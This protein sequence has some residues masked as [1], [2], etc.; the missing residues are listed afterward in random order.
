MTCYLRIQMLMYRYLQNEV[1]KHL[2]GI[3]KATD[4]KK[5]QKSAPRA[6][7]SWTR[8]RIRNPVHGSKDPDP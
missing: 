4:E 8:I 7:R 5:E 3:L 6:G 1:A 2:F